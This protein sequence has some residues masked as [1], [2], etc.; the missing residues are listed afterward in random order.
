MEALRR[1]PLSK[2]PGVAETIDWAQALLRLR[3]E[4]LD[5]EGVSD[6]LGCVLKDRHDIGELGREDLAALVAEAV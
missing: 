2:P 1:R 4:T 6:T 5:V 3:R